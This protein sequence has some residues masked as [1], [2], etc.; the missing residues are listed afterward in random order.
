MLSRLFRIIEETPMTLGAWVAGFLGI[1]FIRIFLE[2]FSERRVGALPTSDTET[3]LH[4]MLWYLATLTAVMV[5]VHLCTGR[6]MARVAKVTLFGFLIVITPPIVDFIVTQG[7][8]THM[9]YLFGT[10]EMLFRNYLT[11][12]FA[13]P[14]SIGA[15]FGIRIELAILTLAM[16]AYARY[17]SGSVLRALVTG[18]VFYTTIFL[19]GILPNFVGVTSTFGWLLEIQQ[20]LLGSSFFRSDEIFSSLTRTHDM[21]FNVAMAH[22]CMLVLIPLGVFVLFRIVPEKCKAL[23]KNAR[24]ERVLHYLLAVTG[25]IAL[26]YLEHVGQSIPYGLFDVTTLVLLY[27]SFFLVWMFAIAVNDIVDKT[28]DRITNS[29]RPLITGALSVSEMRIAAGLFLGMALTTG[30]L[31]GHV[32]FLTILVFI[33]ISWIYSVSPFHLKRFV[34]INSFCI[35]LATLSAVVA[36]FFTVSTNPSFVAFPVEW[37]I[38]VLIV[39]TLIGNVK[40]IKDVAGDRIA[41]VYTIPVIF[42][43]ARGRTI[44]WGLVTLALILVP[45]ILEDVRFLIPGIIASVCAY[46]LLHHNPFREIHSFLLYFAYL[47]SLVVVLLLS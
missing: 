4:Y 46:P 21:Y 36:G 33:A 25:G 35:A 23:I 5:V 6:D 37:A 20:S 24:P 31:A 43:D 40:D 18:I 27:L 9:A 10:P 19:F 34:F 16:F 8:G 12:F 13:S 3:M 29:T 28:S 32:A 47:F 1:V 11:W 39:F 2:N 41:H 14:A 38:L 15:T 22:I 26:A 17:V 42:G 45:F 30:F 44:M 7:S